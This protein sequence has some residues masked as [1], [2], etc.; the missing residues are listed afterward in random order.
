MFTLLFLLILV[1]MITM[2]LLQLRSDKKKVQ[3]SK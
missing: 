2:N 3:V 1:L